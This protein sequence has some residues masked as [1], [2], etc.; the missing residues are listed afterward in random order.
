M[1]NKDLIEK[2]ARAIYGTDEAGFT[3]ETDVEA[4]REQCRIYARAA[5]S[6]M[7]STEKWHTNEG[8][9]ITTGIVLSPYS[10]VLEVTYVEDG[11]RRCRSALEWEE[12][13]ELRKTAPSQSPYIKLPT[14]KGK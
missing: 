13:E 5:I 4:N 7:Q 3:Y 1:K 8:V 11:H 12:L 2:I 14:P 9:E 10:N 6:A